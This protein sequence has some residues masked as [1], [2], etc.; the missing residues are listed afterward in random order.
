MKWFTPGTYWKNCLSGK[1]KTKWAGMTQFTIV[2]Q[3]VWI[4]HSLMSYF[5]T[6]TLW[7]SE[8][9]LTL[10]VGR[11]RVKQ[12]TKPVTRW[13]SMAN[14]LLTCS[15]IP[16]VCFN[17]RNWTP[18][19]YCQCGSTTGKPC[20]LE[21]KVDQKKQTAPQKGKNKTKDIPRSLGMVLFCLCFCN[22]WQQCVFWQHINEAHKQC[23]SGFLMSPQKMDNATHQDNAILVPK[24][25]CTTKGFLDR[26]FL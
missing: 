13:S 14:R 18:K 21:G 24:S 20:F 8:T 4:S 15:L 9:T 19:M 1:L 22:C 16:N 11:G 26:R 7:F 2:L 3:P 5:R 25:V 10:L 17:Q 12:L 6:G 23:S